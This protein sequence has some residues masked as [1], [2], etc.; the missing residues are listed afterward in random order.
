MGFGG[1]PVSHRGTPFNNEKLWVNL[2]ASFT[3]CYD[4]GKC[5]LTVAADLGSNYSNRFKEG[6]VCSPQG[7][8]DEET[9]QR[10]KHFSKSI[11]CVGGA[12]GEFHIMHMSKDT[13]INPSAQTVCNDQLH[14]DFK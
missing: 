13:K 10:H 4:V 14:A 2:K 5:S 6:T 11:G 8:W 12:G 3:G 1:A 7:C 9:W